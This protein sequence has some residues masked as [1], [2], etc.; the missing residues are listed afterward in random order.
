MDTKE[1]LQRASNEI[2]GLRSHNQ[3]MAARLEVFDSMMLLFT[4]PPA[5]KGG[6]M[7][8]DIVYEID[9]AIERE[10]N[11]PQVERLRKSDSD[12]G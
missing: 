7:S 6:A 2:K 3:L 4:S 8:P 12:H 5:Y 9:K 1:L 11:K 10:E